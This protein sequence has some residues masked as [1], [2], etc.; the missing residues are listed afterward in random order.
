M[1]AL[2]AVFL[3]GMFDADSDLWRYPDIA[4]AGRFEQRQAL[5]LFDP[6]RYLAANSEVGQSGL[7]PFQIYV[8][9][10]RA[11]NA[12]GPRAEHMRG[13]WGTRGLRR[14]C[15]TRSA[16]G[17]GDANNAS[18]FSARSQVLFCAAKFSV[19]SIGLKQN[20]THRGPMDGLPGCR[21][22]DDRVNSACDGRIR[23]ATSAATSPS[24]RGQSAGSNTTGILSCS[25]RNAGHAGVVR[26]VKLRSTSPSESRQPSHNPAATSNSPST[27]AMVCGILPSGV[28]CHS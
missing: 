25:A 27:R 26:M 2:E 24:Q 10:G 9:M 12:P 14:V 6:V 1:G 11:A 3:A 8:L 22:P 16:T 4:Q 20:C 5:E 23:D 18:G 19:G 15:Q 17:M 7:E 21:I 13:P 28:A